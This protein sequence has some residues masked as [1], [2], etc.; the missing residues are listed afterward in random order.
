MTKV[1]I[2]QKQIKEWPG[3]TKY[4]HDTNQ[5]VFLRILVNSL[6]LCKKLILS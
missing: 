4:L 1:N 3:L 5:Q 6:S 2:H